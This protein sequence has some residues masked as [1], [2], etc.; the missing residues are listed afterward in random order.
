MSRVAIVGAGPAGR[1]LSLI[2]AKNNFEV[3]LYEKD[4][5]GG[6][7][8]NYGCT[9]FT[10]LREIANNLINLSIIKNKKIHL[11]EIVS[12]KELQNKIKDVL[13]R[14]RN[15]LEK[16]TKEAGVNIIYKE[17][18]N[19][20]KDDYDY[21]VYATGK[22]YTKEFEN[23]TLLNHTD[24]PNLKELPEKLLVIGGGTVGLEIAPVFSDFGSDVTLY[25]RSEILKDIKDEDIKNYIKKNLI[26]FEITYSKDRLKELLDNDD[27]LKILA[28]GGKSTYKTDEFL[29]I[30]NKEFACGDCRINSFG[31]T[32]AARIDALTVAEN[33]IRLTKNKPLKK[34]EYSLIPKNIRLRLNISYVGKQTNKYKLVKSSVGMN[35]FFRVL[36]NIG[37]NK[38]YYENNKVVGALTMIPA[39]EVVPYFAQYIKGINIYENFIETHPSTDIFYKIFKYM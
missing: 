29:R 37:I 18:K 14:I 10:G 34:L 28:I 15:K 5:L 9:Y 12:F 17:F 3:D 33:I 13:D 20:Y 35:N 21:I 26:D 36:D 30:N 19:D 16:E 38:I 31:N 2:L 22:I 25:S 24:I 8:L 4:K 32:P 6:T 27:Y 7:C 23:R 1:L 39:Y 11:E